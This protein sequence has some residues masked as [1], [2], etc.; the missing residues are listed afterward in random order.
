MNDNIYSPLGSYTTAH[1]AN[2]RESDHSLPTTF[3]LLHIA[4]GVRVT[5]Y[6]PSIS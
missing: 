6:F 5:V 1:I 4:N 2:G 3:S